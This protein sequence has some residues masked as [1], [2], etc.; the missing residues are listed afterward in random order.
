MSRSTDVVLFECPRAVLHGVLF[1]IITLDCKNNSFVVLH[2]VGHTNGLAKSIGT[3]WYSRYSTG[4][5]VQYC[6]LSCQSNKTAS[7]S[8]NFLRA[9]SSHAPI[10][11]SMALRCVSLD[12]SAPGLQIILS[13]FFPNPPNRR[14][15]PWSGCR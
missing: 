12:T 4:K 10:V 13:S 1:G 11:Y 9:S 3:V 6:P 15:L 8:L 2:R 5:G 14:T 7:P